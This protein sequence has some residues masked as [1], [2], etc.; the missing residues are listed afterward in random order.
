MTMPSL[1]ALGYGNATADGGLPAAMG[2]RPGPLLK[3]SNRSRHF[4]QSDECRRMRR[5]NRLRRLGI[6]AARI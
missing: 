4:G 3:G 2:A 5:K 6:G 1:V